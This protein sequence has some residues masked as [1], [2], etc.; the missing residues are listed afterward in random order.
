MSYFTQEFIDFFINL[1]KNNNRDWFQT[2]KKEYE[3]QV[4][5]PFEIFVADLIK[6]ISKHDKTIQVLPKDCIFR[7]YRDIR[8][9]KDKSPYKLNTSAIIGRQGRKGGSIP[10]TYV[11]LSHQHF[12]IYGGCYMPEKQHLMDI[13]YEIANNPKEFKKLY[14]DKEFVKHFGEL[15]GEKNK[16]LPADLKEP[17]STEAYI[18]NKQFYYFEQFAPKILLKDD[19]MKTCEKAYCASKPLLDYLTKAGGYAEI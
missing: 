10:G 7:I 17:A 12:R 3:K 14:T 8:F 13:R 16:I 4:K 5:K 19:L 15:R 9:S 11:E 2:N 1:E 18:F 6:L